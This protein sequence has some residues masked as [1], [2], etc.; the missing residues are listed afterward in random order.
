ML[1]C[2][3]YS[4]VPL[5]N[6]LEGAEFC[7]IFVFSDVFLVLDVILFVLHGSAIMH[8]ECGAFSVLVASVPFSACVDFTIGALV[9][10]SCRLDLC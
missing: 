3:L 6:W 10:A 1:R 4:D 8:L 5:P 7:C 2:S 9:W